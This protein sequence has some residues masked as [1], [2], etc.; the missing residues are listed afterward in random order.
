LTA[1]VSDP[2]DTTF[3]YQWYSNNACTT[4]INNAT[5]STY[6]AP[7]QVD[8]KTI[9]YYYKAFDAQ[10]S[11]SN[12]AKATATWNNVKPTAVSLSASN[13]TPDENTN[14]TLTAS[15]SDT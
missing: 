9:D 15:G 6:T 7:A 3:T 4:T 5:S 10:G 14:V 8:G 2:G 1:N 11:G 12:C 13:T